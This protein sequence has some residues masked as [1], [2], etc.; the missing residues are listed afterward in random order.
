MAI[1]VGTSIYAD[2]VAVEPTVTTLEGADTLSYLG[3]KKKQLLEVANATGGSLTITLL[4][5]AASAFSVPGYGEVDPTAGY[6]FT[7]ADGETFSV[8]LSGVDKFINDAD[9][10]ISV[11]G[12]TGATAV[13]Y[14][15]A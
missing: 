15:I 7:V 11:T 9:G 3:K 1:I 2:A 5:D 8:L 13:L 12:G 10:S 6:Q 14:N 4:G